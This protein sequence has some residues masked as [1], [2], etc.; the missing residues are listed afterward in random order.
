MSASHGREGRSSAG[1]GW[2]KCSRD[3]LTALMQRERTGPGH[4]SPESLPDYVSSQMVETLKRSFVDKKSDFIEV[5]TH[6]E[7]TL[8]PF[9]IICEG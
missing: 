8:R 7:L 1:L 4:K 5:A 6:A 9:L 2:G 3:F